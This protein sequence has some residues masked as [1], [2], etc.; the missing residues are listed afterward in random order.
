MRVIDGGL[1][2]LCKKTFDALMRE[3]KDAFVES[4]TSLSR[5]S[6]QKAKLLSVEEI[7]TSNEASAESGHSNI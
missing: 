7:K 2:Q 6:R 3:D 1:D 4:F 5:R